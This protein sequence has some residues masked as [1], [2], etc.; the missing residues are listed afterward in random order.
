M[1][2]SPLTNRQSPI[3]NHE[4]PRPMTPRS[5]LRLLALSAFSLQFFSPSAF[6]QV[7]IPWADVSK[8]GS[9]LA[10]LTTRSAADLT[11]GTL[12]NARLDADLAAIAGLTSAADKLP[13]FTGSGTASVTDLTAFARTI[14][15]DATAAAVATTLG[16]GTGNSPTF[17][18]LTL[19]GVTASTLSY[20]NSSKAAASVTLSGLTLTTGTLSVDAA[21]TSAAGKVELATDAESRAG[22]STTLV[23][24]VSSAEARALHGDL[25]RPV[26]DSVYSDGASANR[27]AEWTPGTAGAV[28]AMAI[29]IPFEFQVPTSNPSAVAYVASMDGST[30]GAVAANEFIVFFNLS[31]ALTI[32]QYGATT[33]DSRILNYSGFRSA[34]SGLWVRGVIVF[35]S[36]D[37]TTNP[38]I[39]VNGV[40][41][42]S[43]FTLSTGGT[44]PNWMP[45]TLVTTYFLSGYA[46]PA[47]RFIPH[48]PIL[49]ALTA[50]EVL[51]WTQTGRLPTWC[52]IAS[53]SAANIIV[54]PADNST[55]DGVTTNWSGVGGGSVTLD[56]TNDE[57]DVAPA[58]S[59]HG[60][61]IG[62][63]GGQLSPLPP[64][65]SGLV[66]KFTLRNVSGGTVSLVNAS[67]GS[68]FQ[69]FVSG[70]TDG[71]YTYY[72]APWNR[73]T[74]NTIQPAF[75]G[76]AA[77][78]FSLDDVY[79]YQAGPI[80]K[81][82]VQPGSLTLR[83][84][85]SNNLTGIVTSG[86]TAI[87]DQTRGS[88]TGALTWS[89]THES[90]S[91][92]G[93]QALPSN[94][95][96]TQ[97]T[98]KATASSSGSGC[99]IGTTNSATRWQA[100]DTF[101]T[102]KEVA[103]LANQLPAGTAA[104][105]LDIV[106]DPDTANFTGSITVT[107]HYIVT[108]GAP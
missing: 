35:E 52:E 50:A 81:P 82:V 7:T 75:V 108:D 38:K 79:I 61:R 33:S 71:T 60:A 62:S 93:A 6:S 56:T 59:G 64:S 9:S 77:M 106:V 102:A 29:S 1:L 85:G 2:P 3:A 78:S 39:Y 26:R 107:V 72:F 104:N 27:R 88:F 105:D 84:A 97:I 8:T 19:S 73:N 55:F 70:L 53:G 43:S 37:T 45:T 65:G 47:G 28:A 48:G 57:L 95:M 91:L 87:T 94:A 18:G 83:D 24:S 99:T 31:G 51:E 42:S 54:T 15:D 5:F 40:D 23:P 12:D 10:D 89:G 96:I 58:A 17:T 4:I 36:G 68:V 103:T 22:T 63:V 14:L 25:T 34:Y 41:V 74:S 80:I 13:Y 21:T 66:V 16:L 69:T 90:K 20:W 67:G 30:S 32:N 44:A 98:R 92:L 101:T 46:W 86:V 49:G 100:A 76:S 11:S